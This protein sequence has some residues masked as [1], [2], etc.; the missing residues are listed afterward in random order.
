VSSQEN[1]WQKN[2]SKSFLGFQKNRRLEEVECIIPDLAGMS[3]GRSMPIYK[4]TPDTTFSLPISLFYQTI[5]G[6][7]VDMDIANQWM[8]KDI[9][10]RPDME[11]ASA[12]PWADDATLQV[13][14]DL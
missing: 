3:R 6:E 4:F 14:N 9:V 7:Y 13:I 8:E 10:L 2:L 12:V 5:S 11:T 1:N